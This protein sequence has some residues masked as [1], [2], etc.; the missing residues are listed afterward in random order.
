MLVLIYE[1]NG[2]TAQKTLILIVIT[3]RIS[4][5]KLIKNSVTIMVPGT[6]RLNLI[7]V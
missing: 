3:V 2:I 1:T 5:L 7:S 4:K 6:V